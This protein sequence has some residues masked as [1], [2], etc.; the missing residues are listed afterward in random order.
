MTT[1]RGCGAEIVWITSPRGKP[2]PCDPPEVTV[3]TEAGHVV[4]GRVSHWATCPQAEQ[5]RRRPAGP[6]RYPLGEE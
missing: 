5:F 3:V 1:C 2:I 4:S 6:A